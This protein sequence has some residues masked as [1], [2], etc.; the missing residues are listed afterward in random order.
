MRHYPLS[1]IHYQLSTA[2][3]LMVITVNLCNYSAAFLFLL[4]GSIIY[5]QNLF[6]RKLPSRKF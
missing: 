3:H 1:T 6:D 4:I 5:W 2:L